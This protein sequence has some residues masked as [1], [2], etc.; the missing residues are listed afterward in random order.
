MGR[1]VE[2]LQVRGVLGERLRHLDRKLARG[3]E[4]Q[5]LRRLEVEIDLL[6]HRGNAKAAV[7]PVP[8]WAWPST[9]APP[10]SA[11]MVCAWMGEG[12]S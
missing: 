9:S 11:G 3:H 2:A 7:L 1:D 6:E 10:S 4:D 8:V 12:D 5:R